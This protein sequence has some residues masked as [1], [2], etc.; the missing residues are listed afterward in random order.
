ERVRLVRADFLLTGAIFSGDVDTDFVFD[1]G[2]FS[3]WCRMADL[4]DIKSLDLKID[5]RRAHLTGG[6]LFPDWNG[7]MARL[8]TEAQLLQRPCNALPKIICDLLPGN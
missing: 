7:A 3:P 5:L 1:Y 2:I 4:A 6:R 8:K